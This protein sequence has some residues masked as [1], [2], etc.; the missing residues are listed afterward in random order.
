MRTPTSRPPRQFVFIIIILSENGMGEGKVD[1][2]LSRAFTPLNPARGSLCRKNTL[3]PA[4][5][6]RRN[7]RRFWIADKIRRSILTRSRK[8]REVLK[9]MRSLR[10]L[11]LKKSAAETA[12]IQQV[13]GAFHAQKIFGSFRVS[14][15]AQPSSC[16]PGTGYIQGR[17]WASSFWFV[18]FPAVFVAAGDCREPA[19]H[20]FSAGHWT[21]RRQ[22]VS[23]QNFHSAASSGSASRLS[24]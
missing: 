22:A 21:K 9:T 10:S 12:A 18:H 6:L 2:S 13:E 4:D 5:K 7:R 19:H 15:T 24:L 1:A 14:L 17:F 8:V 20:T 23:L 16:S 3:C 11:R